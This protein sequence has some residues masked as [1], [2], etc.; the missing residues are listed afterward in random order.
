MP[1]TPIYNEP[2]FKITFLYGEMKLKPEFVWI[3]RKTIKGWLINKYKYFVCTP[4]MKLS[5]T[6]Y[7][8]ALM[9]KWLL[10]HV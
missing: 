9:F 8:D 7:E 2:K 1:G 5:K 4:Y 6:N 10:T 3:G